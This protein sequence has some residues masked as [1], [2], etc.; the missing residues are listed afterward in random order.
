MYTTSVDIHLE[1]GV[2]TTSVEYLSTRGLYTTSVVY[3][4]RG[5]V[6]TTSV[7]Y[8]STHMLQIA[9]LLMSKSL[10]IS[11]KIS[12]KYP[13]IRSTIRNHRCQNA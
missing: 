3:L 6:Y 7:E 2:Y 10:P 1:G 4:C 9:L 8:L 11:D 12:R 13:S 5:G